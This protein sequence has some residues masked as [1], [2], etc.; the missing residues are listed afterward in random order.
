MYHLAYSKMRQVVGMTFYSHPAYGFGCPLSVGHLRARFHCLLTHNIYPRTQGLYEVHLKYVYSIV[1]CW[2]MTMYLRIYF[3]KFTNS[4]NVNL[5][6][7]YSEGFQL[8]DFHDIENVYSKKSE[9]KIDGYWSLW[10]LFEVC[11][12][13]HEALVPVRRNI[14][15]R[16]GHT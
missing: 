15:I 10:R 2:L 4:K 7:W 9:I 6:A 1:G 11:K 12:C 14:D 8:D 5:N 13:L 16:A 3:H